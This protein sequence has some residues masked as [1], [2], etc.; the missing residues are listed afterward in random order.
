MIEGIPF[1][2]IDLV[3]EGVEPLV[4]RAMEY[5]DGKMLSD[6]VYNSLKLKEM[7]LWLV[8]GG[9]WVTRIVQYPQSTRL[10]WIA[11]AGEYQN[12]TEEFPYLFAWAKEQG[13]DAVEI[14]GRPGWGRKIGYEEIHRV[15]RV[16]LT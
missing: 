9:V 2:E 8:P 1:D 11:A 6:D 15:F 5:S 7:Q 16:K 13:C 3:W 12:W 14:A 4:D 10:E